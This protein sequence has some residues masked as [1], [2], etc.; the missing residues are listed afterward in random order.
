MVRLLT[1]VLLRRLPARDDRLEE[2]R[3]LV[4]DE[5]HQ[6]H[7][8]LATDYEDTL[9]GVTVGVRT[10]QDVEQ[11]AA[12]DVEDDVLEPYVAL[13]P[14][15]RVLRVV[16]VEVLE[17]LEEAGA[18]S[19]AGTRCASYGEALATCTATGRPWRSQIAM[20]VVPLPRQRPAA[21]R[22]TA[23]HRCDRRVRSRAV[24]GLSL[25]G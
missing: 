12:L 3:V 17:F 22:D 5:R 18:S 23:R 24:K 16:P 20:I 8:T 11:V 4:L 15:F 6:V 14:E 1:E 19:V 21:V 7:V 9:A 25:R 2:L 13:R 10:F